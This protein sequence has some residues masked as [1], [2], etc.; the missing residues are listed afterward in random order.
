[1]R[2]WDGAP[3][4]AHP[5]RPRDVLKHLPAEEDGPAHHSIPLVE[6]SQTYPRAARDKRGANRWENASPSVLHLLDTR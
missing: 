3:T 2:Q 1:M 5:V 4:G 6:G